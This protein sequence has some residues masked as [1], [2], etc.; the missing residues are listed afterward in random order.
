MST[1]YSFGQV[2]VRP[3]QR[4]VLVEGQPCEL[5]AR[6]FDLL[7][8]L[9]EQ[10]E[11]VVP[12]AEL[13]DRVWP[14][15]VVEE[16]NL[17]VQ[18][19][20]LR[21]LLGRDVVATVPGRG[22]QFSA[23]LITPASTAT[24]GHGEADPNAASPG[25]PDTPATRASGIAGPRPAGLF[26]GRKAELAQLSAA[27][28]SARKGIGRVVLLAGSGGMGKTQLVQ[29][30]AWR[31]EAQDATVLWGRCLEEAGAPP[32]WPW[33][34]LIRA[35]LRGHSGADPEALFGSGLDDI[36]GIVPEV[37]ERFGVSATRATTG[38]SQQSRFQLFDAVAGF[39]RR[40]AQQGPL[41]LIFEDLHWADATSLRLFSFLA[42]ELA[43][44]AM[45]VVGTYRDTELSRQHPLFDTL[46]EMARSDACQ[47]IE[48]RG[49]NVQ[50]TEEFAAA[51]G[52]GLAS[53][54]LVSAL[55]KRTEGHPLFLSETLRYLI[56]ARAPRTLDGSADDLQLLTIIPTGVREVIGKRLNR[57]L[58]AA[59]KTLSVAAC[60]GRS[61]DLDLLSELERDK[62]ED[63]LL[64]ALEE[65]L[66][67]HLI[68]T[69]PDS[70]DLRFSHALIREALYDEMLGLRRARL[71]LRI[72]ELLEL[73]HGTEDAT[74]WSQLAYHFSEAG[75]GTAAVKAL[76]YAQRA[77]QHA[78]QLVAFEES[79][80]LYR[81]A[82]Q[83]LNR[84]FSTDL[85]QRCQVLLAL[86]EAQKWAGDAESASDWFRQAAEA[87]RQCELP[88]SFVA[89]AIG[90]SLSSTQASQSGE[91]AVAMLQEAI[92]LHQDDD[93]VRVELIARLCVAYVYCDRAE[94]AIEA[95]RRA[96]ALARAI[97]DT[98]SLYVALAAIGT[99]IYWP[100]M[101][102][103]RLAASRE[104]WEIAEQMELPD[105]IAQVLPYYLYDLTQVGSVEL[106][107]SLSKRWGQLA[108]K[109]RAPYWLSASQHVEVLSAINEGR[110]EDA[111]RWAAKAMRSARSVAEDKA[112][113]AYGM[114][115]FCLR[116]EQGRLHEALPL[117]QH[118]VKSTP[119]SQIWKPG[120]TLIYAE[121][122]MRIE[123]QAEYDSVPWRMLA[124][125]LSDASRTTMAILL[126]EV[127]VYLEDVVR[128]SL[129]YGM[130]KGRAGLILLGD[131]SGP[132]LGA[133][134]RLLGSLATVM[135]Q[136]D[137]AQRHFD[138]AIAM[139]TATGGRVWLAHSRQRYAWMLTRR[140]APGDLEQAQALCA[141]SLADARAIGMPTL[142]AR[143][144]ALTDR[145][146]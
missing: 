72:G 28:Q 122:D 78:E 110:F 130:L 96:V 86:G 26:V 135:G 73:R 100:E 114:Q 111:E 58:P 104:A 36:A 56:D 64:Q 8:C 118:F 128:A 85:A 141:D 10:R 31:A 91:A 61:F 109:W 32:Y 44:I 35:Y 23:E 48:L 5:G 143:I 19:S 34:Q 103:E 52:R 16:N 71:H 7:L 140:A 95:H 63:D 137:V 22:Y 115:M 45:L 55:Y 39:W 21:K 59:V 41:L 88:A 43:D 30:L 29:Q 89:S 4:L 83:L 117:L 49:L 18:V 37:S 11:R 79:A 97:D 105:R 81:L 129:F 106:L 27:L 94:E 60:I 15:V 125:R 1:H 38:D 42:H 136:W 65:A 69:V 9:I 113:S 33:R 75:A 119:D 17:S 124:D 133:A 99:A 80:R 107:S 82:L 146:L 102:G 134:D 132:C 24:A 6:A 13:L 92:A 126:A 121:L 144:Q 131:S 67:E 70:H 50:E 74:V 77:G 14:D 51:A 46:A 3:D 12:K 2:E 90:F 98:R 47:R 53:T 112:V 127:C 142:C 138:T 123:C 84:H 25:T 40:A 120:L 145:K 68:E 101:L 76:D 116:R 93:S 20:A 66:T 62:S 139:D 57:L 54:A 87:A 108:T